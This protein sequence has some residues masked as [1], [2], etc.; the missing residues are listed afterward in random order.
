VDTTNRRAF[1]RSTLLGTSGAVIAGGPAMRA[2]AA[3]GDTPVS[4]P[5]TIK[6]KLGATGIE[7]PVVSMG[8]MRA[9]NPELVRAALAAGIT[10]LDTAHG[11]QK[12]RNEEMLGEVLKDY[13]R[14]AFVIATKVP[15]EGGER[16]TA[17]TKWLDR[18]DKS[19]QRLKLDYVDII[20]LHGTDD[21][22]AVLNPAMLEALQT[23]KK[24]GR[25]KHLGVSTHKNEPEVIEA[26]VESG[27]I[28]VVLTAINFTQEHRDALQKAIARAG[29]AGMGIVA[30]KTMAGGFRDKER[31]HP[32]NCT[33]ALKWALQNP[34]VT[35]AIPGITSFE[36]LAEN[37]R[38]NQNI[39][40]TDEERAAVAYGPS[41]GSLYCDGCQTCVEGCPNRL[42]I[43]EYMRA[44]MY[45][46]GYRDLG[47]AHDL[48]RALPAESVQCD[49]C[50]A[51]TASCAKGFDVHSRITDVRRVANIPEEFL[52]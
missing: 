37:A 27:V 28:E 5:P 10:H 14:D 36:T 6:R 34:Y 2:F 47:M 11:Y 12:G 31:Q 30:M 24:T 50:D 3:I 15:T 40:L 43:P 33:A 19:L 41:E 32:I 18:L 29:K 51:C 1:L 21:R 48:L 45:T 23:A 46:Y 17:V 39:E 26:A 52:A 35:T 38:V 49:S 42:P 22:D 16:S 44:F 25:A 13:K 4:G 9:D 20:Y 8:V 7:L